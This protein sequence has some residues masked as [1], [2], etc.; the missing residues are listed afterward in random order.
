MCFGITPIYH[1]KEKCPTRRL[2]GCKK[3][4]R[5]HSRTGQGQFYE[6]LL[7]K[8]SYEIESHIMLEDFAEAS[9]L[10][11][12]RYSNKR[13]RSEEVTMAQVSARVQV[14]VCCL[15]KSFWH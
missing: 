10:R 8:C 12:K 3:P 6:S 5:A 11:L 15:G 1:M 14:K 9:E 7:D 4:R 2:R 13:L